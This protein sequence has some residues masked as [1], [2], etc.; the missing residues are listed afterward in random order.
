[1]LVTLPVERAGEQVLAGESGSV[2]VEVMIMHDD[3]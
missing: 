1:M 2:G 3:D